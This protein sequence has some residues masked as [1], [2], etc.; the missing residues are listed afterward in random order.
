MT[1]ESIGWSHGNNKDD[2][3]WKITFYKRPFKQLIQRASLNYMDS[4]VSDELCIWVAIIYHYSDAIM[5]TIA[6]QLT[7]VSIVYLTVWSCAD[8]R[9]HQDT[10]SLAFVR[11]I[12]RWPVTR[13]MFPFDD[14]IMIPHVCISNRM[15][16]G[17]KPKKKL[18]D[19]RR[20]QNLHWEPVVSQ[21]ACV[22]ILGVIESKLHSRHMLYRLSL[23]SIHVFHALTIY[24][25]LRF[26]CV[27][28]N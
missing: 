9:K 21:C 25:S 23:Q 17:D 10:A 12:H 19:D 15:I 28:P 22:T 2:R 14:V 18:E 3:L 7:S 16:T 27:V 20:F 4:P 8:Q 6:S 11:G 26:E 5:I 13:K 24:H 1:L